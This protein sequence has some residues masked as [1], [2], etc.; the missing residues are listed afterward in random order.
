MTQS[1]QPYK[2]LYRSRKERMIAG[3]CGG[4]AEYFGIDPTWI[5]L[6]FV[7]LFFIGGST[8]LIYL[9]MWLVVPLTPEGN[10]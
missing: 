6:A 8:L 9:I 5:R 4:L 1:T 10:P 3:V 7:V 2:R